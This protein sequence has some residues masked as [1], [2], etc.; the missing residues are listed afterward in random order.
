V[1]VISLSLEETRALIED[2]QAAG[3]EVLVATDPIDRAFKVK[4]DGG[5]WSPP[6]G[7]ALK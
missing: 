1:N 7:K 5:A 3:H 4:I 6:M 2:L